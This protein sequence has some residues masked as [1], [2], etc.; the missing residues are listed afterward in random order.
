MSDTK[1]SESELRA[2]V[3]DEQEGMRLDRF[4]AA[5]FA[6]HSRSRLSGLIEAGAVARGGET[7]KDTNHRVKP[8]EAYCVVL[9]EAKPAL[10]QAQ[11]IP[12]DVVY[13]D[14]DLIVIEKPAGLVGPPPGGKP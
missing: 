13:E 12:L 8:G 7:I 5:A 10:P 4:L 9:P 6:E 2:T 3:A 11:D 14:K 1:I